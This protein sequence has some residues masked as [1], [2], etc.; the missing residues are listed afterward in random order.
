MGSG[1]TTLAMAPTVDS[2]VGSVLVDQLLRQLSA[3]L[4]RIASDPTLYNDVVRDD[5]ASAA[6]VA[7]SATSVLRRARE[8]SDEWPGCS[9]TPSRS[10]RIWATTRPAGVVCGDGRDR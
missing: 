8:R 2:I 4:A 10:R 6:P 9:R 1:Q 5:P 7:W 3:A